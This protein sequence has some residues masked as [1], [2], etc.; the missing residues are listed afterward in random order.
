MAQERDIKYVDR[1]FS[2]F[3]QQLIDYTKN[4]FPDT[5]N[6]FSPTSPGM[7]FMEMAAYVGDVLSFYQDIQLQETFLQYAQEPGNL[8]NMAYMM[9]YRPRITSPSTVDL[10]VYQRVPATSVAGQNVPNYDYALVLSENIE[11]QSITGTPVK[12]LTQNKVNFA[13][14]SSYDP[15]TVSVYATAGGTVTEFLLT[16]KVKAISAEVKTTT[17]EVAS[18]ERFKTVTLSEDNIIGVVSISD[19]TNTWYEVPYLAQDTI[20]TEVA[21]TGADKST[22]PYVMQLQKV[23]YRYVT[24]FTSGGALQIQFGAGTS[25]TDDSVITPN[26]TNVG[27]GDITTG[28]SAIDKAYDPSNFMFTGA[29]GHAP[30]GTLTI[31]YLVG[32]GVEAN[33]PADTITTILNNQSPA[34]YG[35]GASGT[36][37]LNSLAFNNPEPATG[38]KDGD[39]I[40]E[41]RQNSTKAFNE[42]L[43][44]VT[45]EDYTVRALSLPS[46]FGTVAKVFVTQDQISSTQSTTDA[47]ID[48]NPLALSMYVLAY[49]GQKQLTVAGTT[50]KQN[51][52]T[53]LNQYRLVTDAVN[54]KDAFIVN[55]GIKY[56]IVIRPSASAREVLLVCTEALKDYF[57]VDKWS[58]NQP[59]NISKLYTV[60]D[61]VKGVQTVQKIEIDNKTGGDYSQYAYDI[62]GATKGNILYPSYDPCIFEV[63]Y[64]NLDIEGRIT[65]L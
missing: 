41:L 57:A 32:G 44:T 58:I 19:G 60:L 61:K 31:Q 21:N 16:K 30:L 26:P 38:G 42:Q 65:T 4:Y 48:S 43:R 29:Y 25:G 46:K 55:I 59:I 45:K 2:D 49:N 52:K 22:S 8:Y 35:V 18:L 7:M 12:F 17:V 10:D 20:F 5:Y 1:T 15:T 62:K 37:Y 36:T 27:L 23:P 63:K 47:I 51:L 64:P 11:L 54:I 53:Y 3:R 6:D 24:R 56:E 50:L 13:Y 40:E 28:V 33:T 9:G 14:S 34:Y 39:T